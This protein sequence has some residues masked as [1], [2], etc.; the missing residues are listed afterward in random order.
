[1]VGGNAADYY[2]IDDIRVFAE[3]RAF[4]HNAVLLL[5]SGNIKP[6]FIIRNIPRSSLG[7]SIV[8]RAHGGTVETIDNMT[9]YEYMKA[10]KLDV[11]NDLSLFFAPLS[12]QYAG[13]DDSDEPVCRP[14]YT[15]DRNTGFATSHGKIPQGSTVSIRPIHTEDIKKTTREAISYI[16]EQIKNPPSGYKYSAVFIASC[17]IRHTVLGLENAFE[18]EFIKKM[19]PDIA[20]AGFYA[21]GEYCPTSIKSGKARNMAHNLSIALCLL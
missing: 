12:V 11:E 4:R 1:V 18:G 2:R 5:L 3:G 17:A 10:H 9:V 6:A 8:T 19:L 14:F 20:V 7:T 15:M 13:Q 21:Y 16:A